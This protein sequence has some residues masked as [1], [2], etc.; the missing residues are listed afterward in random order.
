[1]VLLVVATLTVWLFVFP[2][3]LFVP[4]RVAIWLLELQYDKSPGRWFITSLDREHP[5]NPLRYH[6]YGEPVDAG[7]RASDDAPS[8]LQLRL[9]APKE[10]SSDHLWP[11]SGISNLV[12][13]SSVFRSTFYAHPPFFK[14]AEPPVLTWSPPTPA[15]DDLFQD[16]A[17]VDP[18]TDTN[19]VS[20]AFL[21]LF[22]DHN[23]INGG[24][25]LIETIHDE[26]DVYFIHV[27]LNC[28]TAEFERLQNR[29]KKF[30]NVFFTEKRYRGKW[31]SYSLI[32][33]ELELMRHA[34][35]FNIKRFPGWHEHWGQ[36]GK[37]PRP[38]ANPDPSVFQDPKYPKP[39]P[40]GKRGVATDGLP[41]YP[42]KFALNLCGRSF[43]IKSN[44]EIRQ[45][46][47]RLPS[48][49]NI[50]LAMRML[51]A[52]TYGNTL[53]NS[54]P[55]EPCNNTPARCM[56]PLCHRMTFVPGHG[57]IWKAHQWFTMSFYAGWFIYQQMMYEQSWFTQWQS[58]LRETIVPD[59]ITIV[60][61][62]LSSPFNRT[63]LA[64]DEGN[65]TVQPGHI[66]GSHYI[67][68]QAQC[69]SYFNY[70]GPNS[71]CM[72]GMLDLKVLVDSPYLFARKIAPDEPLRDA[73]RE[74][75]KKPVQ[76]LSEDVYNF[77]I[78]IASALVA[79]MTVMMGPLVIILVS[80][81]FDVFRV[82][83]KSSD[84]ALEPIRSA[85]P[86]KLID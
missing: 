74:L 86:R 69:K 50:V 11:T 60:S 17:Y 64:M 76:V 26:A 13:E 39:H 42:W 85:K 27:D 2:T 81:L 38:F 43:P 4:R 21:L 20:T 83:E 24:I 63:A 66:I 7:T 29:V 75:L 48:F 31:A 62:V 25:D 79:I 16:A 59:E 22:H 40:S 10:R 14:P 9:A 30:P 33:A 32:Q 23:S 19:K 70:R 35:E 65:A 82:N 49:A 67:D 58:F 56:D 3:N 47:A 34:V 44:D 77:R 52:C 36:D 72:L 78:L 51:P 8:P 28:P 15:S 5:W 84:I 73:L 6:K 57:S 55:P 80:G 54:A 53:S 37:K 45:H 1:M 71:P 68:W 41:L 18:T 61:M 12:W 46:F